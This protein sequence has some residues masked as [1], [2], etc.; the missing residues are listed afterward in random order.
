LPTNRLLPCGFQDCPSGKRRQAGSLADAM[1]PGTKIS[2]VYFGSHNK[3]GYP[4][5]YMRGDVKQAFFVP[6]IIN[7]LR[8][9][10]LQDG[11]HPKGF[12]FPCSFCYLL[13]S[14]SFFILLIMLCTSD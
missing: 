13:R 2:I 4:F 11:Y 8:Q 1:V 7:S 9:H 6:S 12:R 3:N 10:R 14:S 5:Y